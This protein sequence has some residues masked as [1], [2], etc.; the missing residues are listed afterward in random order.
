MRPSE[1]AKE[2]IETVE[3]L[4]PDDQQLLVE[5]LRQRLVQHRRAELAA[6]IAA[7]R[8][9][10]GMGEIRLGPTDMVMDLAV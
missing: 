3:A 9:A 7:A 1:F 10:Y 4:P 6:D 5:I 2:V 8:A